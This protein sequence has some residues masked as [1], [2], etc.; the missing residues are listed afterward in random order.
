MEINFAKELNESTDNIDT[1]EVRHSTRKRKFKRI[2]KHKM[3][4]QSIVWIVY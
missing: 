4:K 2:L 1:K 3:G